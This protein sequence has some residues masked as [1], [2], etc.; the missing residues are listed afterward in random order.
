MANSVHPI[1]QEYTGQIPESLQTSRAIQQG[2]GYEEIAKQALNEMDT[3]KS[4]NGV[5][6]D[7]RTVRDVLQQSGSEESIENPEPLENDR[8][9]VMGVLSMIAEFC[10]DMS[11][12]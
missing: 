4:L 5:L 2:K 12:D 6:E 10:E 11:E 3:F 1:L 7:G 8:L 9:R